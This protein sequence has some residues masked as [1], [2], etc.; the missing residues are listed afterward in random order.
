MSITTRVENSKI[1]P[2]IQ[3]SA[4]II[5]SNEVVDSNV[6]VEEITLDTCVLNQ[7]KEET[8]FPSPKHDTPFD[9]TR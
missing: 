3:H 7:V 6:R 5:F 2:S 1:A 8:K 9:L 4:I